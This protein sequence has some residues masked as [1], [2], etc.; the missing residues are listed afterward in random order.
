MSLTL[1]PTLPR[2]AFGTRA[3]GALPSLPPLRP[4]PVLTSRRAATLFADDAGAAT[5]EYA[6]ATM[7]AVSVRRQ[8]TC[9]R[10]ISACLQG[11]RALWGLDFPCW[12]GARQI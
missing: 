4:L 7:A 12:T 11:A 1:I 10:P 6:V 3:S 5:A 8:V 2:G 9:Q